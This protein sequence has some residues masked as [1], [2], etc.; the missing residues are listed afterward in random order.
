MD[1]ADAIEARLT[2]AVDVTPTG[3]LEVDDA[4]LREA[5]LS[6]AKVGYVNNIAHAF[7]EN[8][9]SRETFEG[10]S[11]DAVRAELTEITGVGTWTV[12][13]QLIFSLGRPDVFPVGDLGIRR[14]M[15]RLY[16][17]IDRTE[18]RER[19]ENWAPYRS[20]ASRYLWGM[21]ET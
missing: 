15:Q 12:D 21:D 3:I 20:Y 14:A 16:G 1:A 17:D 8:G 5:G 7:L 11:E 9:Y 10:M 6:E 18:M 2:A 13:M 19:A 4:K